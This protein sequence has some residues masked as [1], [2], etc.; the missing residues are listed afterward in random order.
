MT[1]R[2]EVGVVVAEDAKSLEIVPNE[3]SRAARA[4]HGMTRA[5]VQ[6]MIVGT[7]AG[8]TREL[9]V[10]G[11]GWNVQVKGRVVELKVGFADTRIVNIKDGVD[12]VVEGKSNKITVSGID[13]QAVGEV[14]A[15]IRSHR[16]PE[17]YNL[18][19]IKYSDEVVIKKEGKAFAG[20]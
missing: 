10:N 18:K 12:V 6:N 15:K 19:G 14:A 1:L 9:E 3:N 5:L 17:P 13:K 16:P 4:F 11:V 20:G 8:F 2:P 7:T